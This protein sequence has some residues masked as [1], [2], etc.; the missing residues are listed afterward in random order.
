MELYELKPYILESCKFLGFNVREKNFETWNIKIPFKFRDEFN[1]QEEIN[2]GFEKT[3]NPNITY[4]TFESYFTQKIAQLVAE[5]NSGVGSGSN[6]R[7]IQSHL[8]NLKEKF[9]NCDFQIGQSKY[10]RVDYLIVWFKTTVNIYLTEEYLKGFKLNLNNGVF[11]SPPEAHEI[12]DFLNDINE[13]LI[14]DIPNDVIEKALSELY[15][16]AQVDAKGFIKEKQDENNKTL[17]NEIKR[18]NEYYDLL[19]LENELAESSK[20]LGPEEELLLLKQEREALIEQQIKKNHFQQQEVTIEPVAILLLKEE[21]ESA[22]VT[23]KNKFGKIDYELKAD[24]PLLL[25]CIVT[26]DS[27]GP[28]TVTS[29]NLIA[30]TDKVFE[31]SSCTKSLDHNKKNNCVVCHTEICNECKKISA[32]SSSIL[33]EEHNVECQSCLNTVS[34]EELHFCTNCNQFYCKKCNS[35]DTCNICNSLIP[36]AAIT[37]Q[38]KQILDLLPEDFRAKKYDLSE[39]GNRVAIL[40]KG[41][42]FKS[43]FIVYD[44][45][46]QKII[47]TQKYGLFNKKR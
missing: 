4:I 9:P 3:G 29:D 34:S 44:K 33:C 40:G 26:D 12:N 28:F 36:V 21:T 14:T 5:Y 41:S 10:E 13:E 7:T 31:C 11:E 42:F 2:I 38:L 47:K 15:S 6:L 19:E 32:I 8:N 27:T 39:K 30:K 20:G 25:Q 1:G 23:I 37:P 17:E 43:F 22:Q 18:I 46:S 24:K 45:I 16:I 35:T